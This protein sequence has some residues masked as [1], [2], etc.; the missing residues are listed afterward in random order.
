MK[1]K[2]FVYKSEFGSIEPI[3][4]AI[5]KMFDEDD[6]QIYPIVCLHCGHLTQEIIGK[7]SFANICT[8][9]ECLGKKESED[10]LS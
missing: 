8:N 1:E 4:F 9:E 3:R 5:G 10:K 7:H 2:K 6:K